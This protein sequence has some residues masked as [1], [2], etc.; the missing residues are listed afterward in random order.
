MFLNSPLGLFSMNLCKWCRSECFFVSLLA[1]NDLIVLFFFFS[2][3]SCI[4]WKRCFLCFYFWAYHPVFSWLTPDSQVL[5][6]STPSVFEG[7][8]TSMALSSSCSTRVLNCWVS[9]HME[10]V[11]NISDYPHYSFFLSLFWDDCNYTKY[12]RE[13]APQISIAM[14]WHFLFRFITLLIVLPHL[15]ASLSAA[16]HQA[17]F[18][19]QLS[20]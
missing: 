6:S 9:L 3:F 8:I 14:Q 5:T 12:Q 1:F 16:E 11:T 15:F 20:T 2:N 18:S 4:V 13:A 19:T 10:A 17:V 7:P